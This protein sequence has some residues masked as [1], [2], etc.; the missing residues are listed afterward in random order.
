MSFGSRMAFCLSACRQGF[1]QYDKIVS[2]Y[3]LRL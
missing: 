3:G 2:V 1:D